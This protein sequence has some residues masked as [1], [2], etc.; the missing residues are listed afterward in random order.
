VRRRRSLRSKTER[1]RGVAALETLGDSHSSAGDYR[2]ALTEYEK[3]FDLSTDDVATHARLAVKVGDC[4]FHRGIATDDDGWFNLPL[5]KTVP[6]A[7][8][9]VAQLHIQQIRTLWYSS[10]TAEIEPLS[11]RLLDVALASQNT[12][13]VASTRLSLA[14]ILHLLS[15]YAEAED[16]LAAID[17]GALPA[18]RSFLSK[19]H[20][21][22]GVVHA[23]SGRAEP[24]FESFS[25][26][27]HY[28]DLGEY[29]YEYISVL[30]SH[31]MSAS[32]LGRTEQAASLF[33]QALNAARQRNLVWTVACISLEC[34]RVA[35]RQGNRDLAHAYVAQAAALENPPPVLREALAEIGILIAL[36]CNDP[37][38]LKRCAD[39]S[40]LTF[41]FQS[42]EP[43]R[44]GPV[45]S[46]FARYFEGGGQLQKARDLLERA[47]GYALNADQ[48]YDL[49]IA[50]AQFGDV[51][52][53]GRARAVLLRR[54]SLPNAAVATALLRHFDAIV[55]DREGNADAAS[56]EATV[57]AGLFRKVHWT[58]S[59]VAA[60]L[61][62]ASAHR[63]RCATGDVPVPGTRS[64]AELSLREQSVAQL[65]LAGLSNREIGERLSISPRTV[66]CHMTSIL[67]RMG[68]RSRH[69]L[70]DAL[71]R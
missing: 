17:V 39:E 15:R 13:L 51:R 48:A 14:T 35:S 23:S 21:M 8:S 22:C 3:A 67:R 4:A 29:P 68:L 58:A 59:E 12:E 10:R 28:S 24:A 56:S 38:L 31:A 11:Q 49:P 1:Q 42:G 30:Q 43:A 27:L 7:A 66:E 53:L 6:D 26:A 5:E 37:Y 65:V 25:R 47:L 46:S 62:A 70:L 54:A 63:L 55:F 34:A 36:E 71:G 16:H 50:V 2:A 9:S 61:L 40:A 20:R 33:S 64:R 32:M 60:T 57:A 19:Y 41:A 18:E 45:A 69:Q 52:S 44:L